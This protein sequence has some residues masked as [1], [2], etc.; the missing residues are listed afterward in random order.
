MRAIPAVHPKRWLAAG[1]IVALVLTVVII[2]QSRVPDQ[3]GSLSPVRD[4]AAAA[5]RALAEHDLAAVEEQLSSYRGRTDFAYYFSA[6]ATPR[7]LGDA[8]ASVAGD[9]TPFEPGLD[10]DQYELVLTDLAGTLA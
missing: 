7:L 8:V 5:V 6:H 10:P 2:N 1:G 3:Q 9:D 4:D